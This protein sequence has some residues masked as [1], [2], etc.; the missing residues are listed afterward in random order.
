[1][2]STLTQ[3]SWDSNISTFEPLKIWQRFDSVGQPSHLA[4]NWGTEYLKRK[5]SARVGV[6]LRQQGFK[7]KSDIDGNQLTGEKAK[8]TLI[9]SNEAVFTTA[10][11]P[12]AFWTLLEQG[13]AMILHSLPTLRISFAK[14]VDT[15]WA[16]VAA[17]MGLTSETF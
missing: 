17:N 4:H 15:A 8:Q 7:A 1:M 6:L 11:K 3:C 5:G 9:S 13:T 2:E 14:D 16:T 10:V 12:I